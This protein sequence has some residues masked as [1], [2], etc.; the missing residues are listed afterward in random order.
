MV[1]FG[2]L[3]RFPAARLD[4][5]CWSIVGKRHRHHAIHVRDGG[6]ASAPLLGTHRVGDRLSH[7]GYQG[8]PVGVGIVG[9]PFD[10]VFSYLPHPDELDRSKQVRLT[11]VPEVQ[12]PSPSQL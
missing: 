6:V 9:R 11:Y 10:Q 3:R 8:G 1:G 12:L 7:R 2:G 4:D 5:Q